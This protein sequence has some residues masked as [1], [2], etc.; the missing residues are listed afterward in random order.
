MEKCKF[1]NGFLEADFPYWNDT[2]NCKKKFKL[3]ALCNKC[4]KQY[5][6]DVVF[7]NLDE[8]TNFIENFQKK[9]D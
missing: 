8:Y 5:H 9:T 7:N 3:Q 6:Y 1:C 4:G 2:Y